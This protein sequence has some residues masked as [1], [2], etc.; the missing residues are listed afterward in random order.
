MIR[1]RLA[2]NGGAGLAP[3][4]NGQRLLLEGKSSSHVCVHYPSPGIVLAHGPTC[5]P[6]SERPAIDVAQL[7]H[8]P[9][10]LISVGALGSITFSTGSA[11]L[12]PFYVWRGADDSLH[13]SWRLEDATPGARLDQEVATDFLEFRQVYTA[14]TLLRG[15][16]QLTERSQ[17]IAGPTEIRHVPP[18]DFLAPGQSE[19]TSDDDAARA[20][21]DVLSFAVREL[22]PDRS[23]TVVELSGGR[24]SSLLALLSALKD[25]KSYGIIFPGE[26]GDTQARRRDRIVRIN[27]LADSTVLGIDVLRRGTRLASG[28]IEPRADLYGPL[29]QAGLRAAGV[30]PGSFVVTGIGGDEAFAANT[31]PGD[32]HDHAPS[33][34]RA[35][36]PLPKAWLPETG[37]MAA[38]SR[39]AFFQSLDCWPVYPYLHADVVDFSYRLPSRLLVDRKLQ[40]MALEL[41]GMPPQSMLRPTPENFS[42]V[43]EF[44][45]RTVTSD[46]SRWPVPERAISST[47]RRHALDMY[48]KQWG[49]RV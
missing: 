7:S 5:A 23:Q 38:V 21:V 16:Y 11:A 42:D 46:A 29:T 17:I 27:H 8:V 28:A 48:V 47:M 14:R 1:G 22:I 30:E 37:L 45:F 36:Y 3:G 6:C 49:V 24:D 15:V 12:F 20:L 33:I 41:L 31:T 40:M 34:A 13:F 18:S 35:D 44:E 2:D 4:A 10:V 26:A 43:L 19:V 39:F 25:S 9:H 32:S